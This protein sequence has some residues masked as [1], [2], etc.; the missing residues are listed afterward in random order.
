MSESS[1]V[2]IRDAHRRYVVFGCATC[3][4]RLKQPQYQSGSMLL[5]MT[6]SAL[7]TPRNVFEACKGDKK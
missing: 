4:P 1:F 3:A 6:G 7:N 5:K 2:N